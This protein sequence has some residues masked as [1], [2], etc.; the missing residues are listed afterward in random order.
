[1]RTN[2]GRCPW[3]QLRRELLYHAGAA[4]CGRRRRRLARLDLRLDRRLAT[5]DL[6]AL[7][8]ILGELGV[9][10]G[11]TGKSA[12]AQSSRIA[13]F[14]HALVGVQRVERARKHGELAVVHATRR[15]MRP[16]L[17]LRRAP[18]G[19]CR[20][21]VRLIQL[22]LQLLDA[23]RHVTRRC[24]AR[25]AIGL[26]L[27]AARVFRENDIN[28]AVSHWCCPHQIKFGSSIFI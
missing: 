5:G 18:F 20:T 26:H 22:A 14:E 16:P 2:P 23:L 21:T 8:G 17:G 9:D 28:I 19:L 3:L 7:G 15:R 4:R 13:R 6:H 1:V 11:G 10:L 27:I 12:V 25:S 24:R